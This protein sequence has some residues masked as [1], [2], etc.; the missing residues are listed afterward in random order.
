LNGTYV[1]PIAPFKQP[2]APREIKWQPS[3]AGYFYPEAWMDSAHK[4]V[5]ANELVFTH[6]DK[7]FF[8]DVDLW[9]DSVERLCLDHEEWESFIKQHAQ[10][11][12]LRGQAMIWYNEMYPL[13]VY[14]EIKAD[15]LTFFKAIS[16]HFGIT[17]HQARQMLERNRFTM[18]SVRKNVSVTMWVTGTIRNVRRSL[19][20]DGPAMT[21]LT[22]LSIAW[23]YIDADIRLYLREPTATDIV[24]M[25]TWTQS[26]ESKVRTLRESV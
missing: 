24:K 17:P 4:D 9:L 1:E 18:K 23:E 16:R 22:I 5:K 7:L 12:L 6:N 2:N 15:W 14:H 13:D 26:F 21:D 11:S 3:D 10:T 8:Q 20:Q 19:G 25:S